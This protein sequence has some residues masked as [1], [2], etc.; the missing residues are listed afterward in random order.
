MRERAT[1]CLHG[2][3]MTE[4][5]TYRRPNGHDE[6]WCRICLKEYRIKNKEYLSEKA[7][8]YRQEHSD[9]YKEYFKEWYQKN[10]EGK[11]A[12]TRAWKRKRREM[13]HE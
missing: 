10:G 5:N 12:Y 9:Y 11:R 4:E 3:E 13:S 2:H 8:K 7:A 6:K 1:H